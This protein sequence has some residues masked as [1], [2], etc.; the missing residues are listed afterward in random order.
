MLVLNWSS[1]DKNSVKQFY[2]YFYLAGEIQ[3]PDQ[4]SLLIKGL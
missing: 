1:P 4:L 3:V 2:I